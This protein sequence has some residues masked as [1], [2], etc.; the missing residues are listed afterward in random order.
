MTY[1]LNAICIGQSVPFT[2]RFGAVVAEFE[3][4]HEAEIEVSGAVAFGAHYLIVVDDGTGY[5]SSEEFVQIPD[6]PDQP[7]LLRVPSQLRDDV[8]A[9]LDALIEASPSRRLA[10]YL[11]ANRAISR[12]DPDDPHPVEIRRAEFESLREFWAAE[13]AGK[14][15]EECIVEITAARL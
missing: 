15:E 2:H 9:L 14:I 7:A 4:P 1:I 6:D 13:K 5:A 10:V 11:E 8:I 3:E 12:Q